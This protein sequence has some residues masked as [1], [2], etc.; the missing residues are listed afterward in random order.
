MVNNNAYEK[1][2]ELY[3]CLSVLINRD[4]LREKLLQDKIVKLCRIVKAM[5]C[6]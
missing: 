2:F 6:L 3:L 1:L 5:C 4:S